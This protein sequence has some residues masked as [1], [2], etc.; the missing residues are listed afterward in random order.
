MTLPSEP[1]TGSLGSM[2]L[3]AHTDMSDGDLP[4]ERVAALARERGVVIG[5]ADHVSSR[6]THRFISNERRLRDYLDALDGAPV[7]R[8]AELCWCDD[9]S[10]SIPDE[11]MDRFDY[12]IGSNHGFALPDGTFGSPWWSELPQAWSDRPQEVMEIMVH[13]LCDMV[14][15]MPIQII[16]HST[17]TPPA[18]YALEPDVHAW[19]TEEREDRF[20]EAAAESGVAIEISNRY[21]LPHDRLLRKALQAGAIFSLGSDGHHEHQIGRLEWAVTTARR[22]GITDAVMFVPERN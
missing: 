1:R 19:W 6:N 18:L 13:N 2:D 16:A 14:C 21:G 9:F 7:L 5:I 8:S 10:Q 12:L 17:L 3:H 20:V 22:V 4:L 11:L 15:A